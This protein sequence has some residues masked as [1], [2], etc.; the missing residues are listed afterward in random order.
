MKPVK[1]SRN[2]LLAQ[3]A[4]GGQASVLALDLKSSTYMSMPAG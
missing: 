3:S 4:E 2:N 1:P